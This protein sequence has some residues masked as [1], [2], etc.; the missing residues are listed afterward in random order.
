MDYNDVMH[1]D[2]YTLGCAGKQQQIADVFSTTI[3][4][5]D[6]VK[7]HCHNFHELLWVTSGKLLHTVNGHQQELCVG[8]L[9]M[10]EPD[11]VHRLDAIDDSG[12][13]IN[14]TAFPSNLLIDYPSLAADS[15]WFQRH[16]PHQ[17]PSY[18]D[19]ISISPAQESMLRQLHQ[20]TIRS[21]GDKI[22]VI[23][24][25][26]CL[27]SVVHQSLKNSISP[28]PA[29]TWLKQL[30]AEMTRT[31]LVIQGR[32]ALEDTCHK[33]ISYIHRMWKKYFN[34]TPSQFINSE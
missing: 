19:V 20:H 16:T 21:S 25:L 7:D 2:R 24:L 17:N 14:N 9:I 22:S 3:T 27:K 1:P 15:E 33:N 28:D 4:P 31:E 8:D 12:G 30:R 26:N 11:D 13:I 23:A 10:I 29:P 18:P 34:Q 32:T 5:T 6:P